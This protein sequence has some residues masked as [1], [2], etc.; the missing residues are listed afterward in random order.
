[1]RTRSRRDVVA[2]TRSSSPKL[3]VQFG[4]YVKVEFDAEYAFPLKIAA[5]APGVH[6]LMTTIEIRDFEIDRA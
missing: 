2:R 5:Q 6:D 4:G 1:V 3:L